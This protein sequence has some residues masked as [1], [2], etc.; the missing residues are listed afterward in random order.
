MS[1]GSSSN[2]TRQSQNS[3]TQPWEPTISSV[4]RFITDVNKTKANLGPTGDQ[5]DAF[6]SLKEKAA[7]GNPWLQQIGNLATD[8]FGAT[9]RSGQVDSAVA[10]LQGQLGDYA[11]GKFLDFENNPYVQK[12]LTE[13]GNNA[14]NAVGQQFAAAGR[15]LSGAHTAATGK[16]I[17]SAQLPILSDL[18]GREQQN[19]INAAQILA[20]AG[21]QGAQTAQGLDKDALSTR[22]GGV[23]LANAALTARDLP[24]NTI[25]NLDQQLKQMP[26]EDLSLYASLL[27]PL[28]GL[29]GTTNSQGT[30]KSK[31][32]SFGISL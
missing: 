2:K 5:L 13:A 32:T 22:A 15:D 24:E 27:L 26:I 10:N 7:Q 6:A 9:S 4:E 23:D 25:L 1:F 19:Q 21:V 17:T 12:M 3:T 30:S 14:R 11:S 8:T 18:F 20:N 16:A 29:G 31:G 28:A